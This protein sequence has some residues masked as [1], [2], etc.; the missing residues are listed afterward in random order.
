VLDR[1]VNPSLKK[2]SGKKWHI[3]GKHKNPFT[4]RM[5]E[6]SFDTAQRSAA[7]PQIRNQW[8]QG[9]KLRPI[10]ENKDLVC[11]ALELTNRVLNE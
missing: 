6:R 3:H 8:G 10:A 2:N 1:T 11:E 4:A 7:L 9:R 5:G